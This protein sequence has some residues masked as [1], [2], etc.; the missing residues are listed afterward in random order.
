MENMYRGTLTPRPSM[1][2]RKLNYAGKI[3]PDSTEI[4]I[5]HQTQNVQFGYNLVDGKIEVNLNRDNLRD[6]IRELKQW[7][8]EN[9]IPFTFEEDSM[10][11]IDVQELDLSDV[12]LLESEGFIK[13]EAEAENSINF[14]WEMRS[15]MEMLL[16]E[17]FRPMSDEEKENCD[18]Y[19]SSLCCGAP[20]E[21][22]LIKKE[23]GPLSGV[24]ICSR[25]GGHTTNECSECKETDCSKR[26][27]L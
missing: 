12:P 27:T 18:G 1:I 26:K 20:I 5:L 16:D 24:R 17:I 9:K 8:L 2:C 14:I 22:H 13:K 23:N 19:C 7:M 4:A 21:K 15:P 3:D 6:A 10:F 11:Y 25:C